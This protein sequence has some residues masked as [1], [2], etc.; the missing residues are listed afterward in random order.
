MDEARNVMKAT[1]EM[2]DKLKKEIREA[3]QETRE[4]EEKRAGLNHGKHRE[5]TQAPATAGEDEERQENGERKT[6][7]SKERGQEEPR[8]GQEVAVVAPQEG[9][10]SD[11]EPN[12]RSQAETQ[13][14][15][16][17]QRAGHGRNMHIFVLGRS[18]RNRMY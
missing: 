17:G 15:G 6:T 5:R 1:R 10:N 4:H 13:Q 11:Q 7:E 2:E 12:D 8:R 9:G 14:K 3:V 16:L 18:A